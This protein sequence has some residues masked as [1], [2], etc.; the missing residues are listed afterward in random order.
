VTESLPRCGDLSLQQRRALDAARLEKR[1]R[2]R[3]IMEESTVEEDNGENG[4][5]L[6]CSLTRALAGDH[7]AV[8]VLEAGRTQR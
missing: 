2:W 7:T 3:K 5:V 6:E 8:A 1:A 4:Q